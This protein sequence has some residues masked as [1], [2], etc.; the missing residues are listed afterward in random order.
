MKV[1]TYD[2]LVEKLNRTLSSDL[3]NMGYALCYIFTRTWSRPLSSG[4][5]INAS[6]TGCTW[7]CSYLL[8][9]CTMSEDKKGEGCG[10]YRAYDTL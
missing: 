10:S 4:G 9:A 5:Y 6:E 3:T 1:L 8:K 2:E 7:N